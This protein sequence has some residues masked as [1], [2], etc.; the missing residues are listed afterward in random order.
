MAKIIRNNR[1]DQVDIDHV[2]SMDGTTIGYYRLGNGPC[3]ILLHGIMESAYC[4]MELAVALSDAYT[5]YLPD[6]RG[7]GL[8]GPYGEGYSMQKEMEDLNALLAKTGARYLFGVSLGGLIALQA[9]LTLPAIRKAAVFDPPMAVN[10]SISDDWLQ[11]F[12]EEMAQ[13]QIA[14]ALVTSMLGA[15]MGPPVF[16]HVPRWLLNRLTRLMM[17]SEERKPGPY[18]PFRK[19]APTIHYDGR[20]VFEISDRLEQF[21]AMRPEVLLLGGNRSPN[22]MKVALHALETIIPQTARIEFPK[23]GHEATG[24]SDRRG[25]PELAAQALRRFFV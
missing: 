6:R 8:S 3:L 7:R 23:H 17:A 16:N 18:I 19:L 14:A 20:L 12:D 25:K 2:L 10:G 11:R 1:N 22:Y 9:A 13:G 21:K 5:V 4:H 15:Q 24:N